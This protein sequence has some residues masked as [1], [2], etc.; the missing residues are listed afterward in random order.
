MLEQPVY[1]LG[2]PAAVRNLVHANAWA[3]L[4]SA[5]GSEPP[6]ISHL[7]VLLDPDESDATVLG[8]L[9]R[10]DADLHRL[11]ERDVVIVVEGPNNY[12]S[13]S[14]Y[15]DGPYVPTW[16]YAVA[17]LHGRPEVF[18]DTDTYRVLEL[19][20][21]H[22]ESARE[23]PWR[24]DS[25]DDF[26]HSIAPYAVGFRLRPTRVASKGKLS[27]DKPAAV[28]ERVV[29]ALDRDP[30]HANRRLA[31]LMRDWLAINRSAS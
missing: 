3:L 27:Q 18:G 20:V 30:V 23:T 1:A 14:W 12:I 10:A 22:F 29:D 16:N 17:H 26:A 2:P 11:G 7:P 31:Q 25:V 19:T 4:A 15:Q 24:L 28:V 6:V 21:E 8:H 5:N 9:P 13:P